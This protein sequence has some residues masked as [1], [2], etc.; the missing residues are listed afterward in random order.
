MTLTGKRPKILV[1]DNEQTQIDT[2]CRGLFLYGFDCQGT[3]DVKSALGILA[4][5]QE[6]FSLVLTDLTMPENSGLGLIKEIRSRWPSLK[7]IVITGLAET[8]ELE[9]VRR[10]GISCLKKPFQPAKL[11]ET[12]RAQLSRQKEL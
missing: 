5:A 11:V 3:L 8:P 12:I 6:C 1:V 4:T 10:M 2:V 9:Q 7:I